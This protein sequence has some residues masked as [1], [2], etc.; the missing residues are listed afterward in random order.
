MKSK[1]LVH[2]LLIAALAVP[3][4]SVFA[5]DSATATPDQQT[6]TQGEQGKGHRGMRGKRMEWMAKQLN[7]TDDQKQQLKQHHEQERQQWQALRQDTS[8]TKEQKRE[9]M[10]A[11]REQDQQFM[12]SILTADQKTKLAQLKQE[13]KARHQHGDEQNQKNSSPQ[14]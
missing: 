9:K 11:M 13:R 5:Q 10:K 6:Q 2:S 3:A 1:V 14:G 12:D 4:E 8:L 7:L